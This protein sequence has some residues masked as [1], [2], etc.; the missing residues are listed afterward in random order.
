MNR[1]ILV[2]ALI[3]GAFMVLPNSV[4]AGLPCNKML[5]MTGGTWIEA[6]GTNCSNSAIS[7]WGN[8]SDK[9]G[10]IS[11]TGCKSGYSLLAV[12][13]NLT[14]DG[15]I[16]SAEY[17]T[18]V[19]TCSSSNCKSDSTWTTIRT[20]YQRL[21]KRSCA[22]NTNCQETPSYRCASGYYGTS[23]NGS[24]GCTLC[25]SFNGIKALSAAGAN[26]SITKCYV[27]DGTVGTDV[28]GTFKYTYA[29][30]YTK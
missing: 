2:R 22:S 19:E 26:S 1:N 12:S 5:C 27:P 28:T 15:N 16:I 24:T 8:S 9:T 25:P 6:E 17:N 11:C 3:C 4:F 10:V 13:Q 30:Y 18:C 21:V 7:C 29:C 14:C 20:G 23:S